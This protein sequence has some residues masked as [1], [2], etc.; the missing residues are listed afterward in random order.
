MSGEPVKI[1]GPEMIEDVRRR[2]FYS[3]AGL[4][5]I[6]RDLMISGNRRGCVLSDGL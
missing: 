3:E 1:G 4:S 2:T 6:R 5:G